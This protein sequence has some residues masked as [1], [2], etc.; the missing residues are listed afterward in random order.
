MATSSGL[1]LDLFL[2]AS[3]K[4][5]RLRIQKENVNF[6]DH[7]FRFKHFTVPLTI[8]RSNAFGHYDCKKAT[9]PIKSVRISNAN[10]NLEIEIEMLV[11]V[12]FETS[13]GTTVC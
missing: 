6:N 8:E 10:P 4:S 1:R 3:L 2:D 5:F 11:G 13:F 7:C 12:V 9:E